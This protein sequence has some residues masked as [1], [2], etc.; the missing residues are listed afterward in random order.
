MT[1][2]ESDMSRQGFMSMPVS[3]IRCGTSRVLAV[4]GS[5]WPGTPERLATQLFGELCADGL[6]GEHYQLNKLVIIAPTSDPH[7]F[8]FLFVQYDRR[9]NS[10]LAGLECGNLCAAAG[11][12]AVDRGI[13]TPAPDGVVYATNV[14]TMQA[15]GI[16]PTSM[17]GPVS[18][19]SVSFLYPE[20]LTP[21]GYSGDE[22][23]EVDLGLET[24]VRF[25]VVD[26]GNLFVLANL[27]PSSL[28]AER[29]ERLEIAGRE[30]AR[31]SGSGAA[32]LPKVIAYSIDDDSAWSYGTPDGAG[33]VPVRVEAA[34]ASGGQLHSS[35]PGSG[36]MCTS[37][38]LAGAKIGTSGAPPDG[39][40]EFEFEHPSGT[41][42]TRAC[43][44]SWNSHTMITATEFLTDV[45]VLIHGTCPIVADEM[46]GT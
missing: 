8:E 3:V 28:T 20:G 27:H 15:V 2:V 33:A 30:L 16:R 12:V 26:H 42:A 10:A 39:Y 25:W 4:I 21:H 35:L 32:R 45:R 24:P 29:A 40:I 31:D 23:D 14:G 44:E 17:V 22:G 46:V 7:H 43:F 5:T 9:D 34:C 11:L 13:A 1:C 41:L 19:F 37:A 36:A 6:G 38:F 18:T